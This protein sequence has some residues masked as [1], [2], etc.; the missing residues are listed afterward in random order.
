MLPGSNPLLH[1]LYEAN[2]NDRYSKPDRIQDVASVWRFRIRIT[3]DHLKQQ[4]QEIQPG[5]REEREQKEAL[6][7]KK[8]QLAI[9]QLFMKQVTLR[10]VK[11]EQNKR[12]RGL[13]VL[14]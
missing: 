4:L 12:P 3:I 5:V 10:H 9:L 13:D 11:E 1:L 6:K 14:L 8:K 2:E 7:G